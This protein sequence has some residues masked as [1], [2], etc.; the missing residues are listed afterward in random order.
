MKII[1]E[2]ALPKW[3]VGSQFS[4]V[5]CKTVFEIEE[6]DLLEINGLYFSIPCPFCKAKIHFENGL[7]PDIVEGLNAPT[8]E[9]TL[10]TA[11]AEV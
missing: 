8:A 11:S 1:T 9:P 7:S 10:D 3:P 4:C 2:G 6:G 5:H